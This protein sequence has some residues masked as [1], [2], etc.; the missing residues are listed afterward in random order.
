MGDPVRPRERTLARGTHIEYAIGSS[1]PPGNR[2]AQLLRELTFLAEQER[3]ATRRWAAAFKCFLQTVQGATDR[4]R[5]VGATALDARTQRRYHRRYDALLAAGTAAEPPPAP[6][7]AH[8]GRGREAP[9][10]K[11]LHRLGRDRAA[12]LRFMTDLAVPFDDSEA[13]RDVRMMRVEQ[14]VSGGFGTPEGAATFCTLRGYL[15]TARKQGK[16]AL[17]VLR[18]ALTGHPFMPAVP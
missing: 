5:A 13:E 11:L 18:D 17:G 16:Q 10:G 6:R 3:P 4:A 7:P 9:G 15:S 1:S 12:V 2:R 14:K 8:G